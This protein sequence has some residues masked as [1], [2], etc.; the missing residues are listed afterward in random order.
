MDCTGQLLPPKAV[1][2]SL[3]S[4]GGMFGRLTTALL[5]ILPAATVSAGAEY[6]QDTQE[7]LD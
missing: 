5:A 3:P 6:P 2:L 7:K 1:S 4:V